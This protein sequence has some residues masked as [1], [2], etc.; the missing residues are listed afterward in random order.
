MARFNYNWTFENL[1]F[2]NSNTNVVKN[3]KRL[4]VIQIQLDLKAIVGLIQLVIC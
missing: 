4:F 2:Q 1:W 3:L